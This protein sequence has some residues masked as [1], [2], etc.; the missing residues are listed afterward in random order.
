MEAISPPAPGS[1]PTNV[2]M[3]EDRA[4]IILH[5][6][7]SSRMTSPKTPGVGLYFAMNGL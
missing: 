4:R 7:A 1:I 5:L 2:P 6:P 3:I